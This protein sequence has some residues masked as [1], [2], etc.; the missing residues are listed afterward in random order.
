[1]PN[2]RLAW[3]LLLVPLACVALTWFAGAARAA[4]IAGDELAIARNW[5]RGEL[6]SWEP[7]A[8]MGL[9]LAANSLGGPWYP[10]NVA[11]WLVG[12]ARAAPWLLFARTLLAGAGVLLLFG[13]RRAAIA[14]ALL[15][16]AGVFALGWFDGASAAD[17]CSWLP[18]MAWSVE[19]LARREPHAGLC[20]FASSALCL[21][22]GSLGAAVVVLA[23][24][25]IHALA[26]RAWFAPAWIALGVLGGALQWIPWLEAAGDRRGPVQS[27]AG[28]LEPAALAAIADA[29]GDGRVMRFD[30]N[31]DA[32]LET[33]PLAGHGIDDLALDVHLAPRRLVELLAAA[34]AGMS[35]ERGVL[36]L[37]Q[38]GAF[39]HPVL[40]LARVTCVIAREP[41]THPRLTLHWSR[42]ELFVYRRSCPLSLARV[43]PAALTE[44]PTDDSVLSLFGAGRLDPARETLITRAD[45][46]AAG[47]A[48][49]AFVPG[50]LNLQRLADDR[51]DVRVQASSGGWLVMHEQWFPG[52]KATVN[53]IDQDIV[54]V[55]HALR[56]VAIGPGDSMV[57]TKY[58][59]DSLRLGAWISV[60]ALVLALAFAW[61]TS[62][63]PTVSARSPLR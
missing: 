38:T 18:W 27:T 61:F 56:A 5:Q 23:L 57:R 29:A 42:A 19:R 53:G 13:G 35:Q 50:E 25:L 7:R 14:A 6:P 44:V 52:W 45:L 12:P 31:V 62:S 2:R 49:A 36:H 15:V 32:T 30:P 16:Q 22:A 3:V 24:V 55:D 20:V 11:K 17:A 8:G 63:S 48:S 34:D 21:C 46:P 26:R 1:M 47:E 10:P 4:R 43:V 9:P 59:P 41:L 28:T 54:R 37:T 39:A 51:L 60:I 40:D 58:E 33:L